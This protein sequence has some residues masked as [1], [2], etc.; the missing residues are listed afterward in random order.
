MLESVDHQ[1]QY[2]HIWAKK[3]IAKKRQQEQ[4]EVCGRG[5]LT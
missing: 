2:V 1:D 5:E 3:T 4:W